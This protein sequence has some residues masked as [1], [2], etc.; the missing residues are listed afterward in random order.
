MVV[1]LEVH[2]LK[3]EHGKSNK[4][5]EQDVGGV[6]WSNQCH[7][8]IVGGETSWNLGQTCQETTW[9]FQS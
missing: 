2:G 3:K 9:V 6:H 4:E 7:K 1:L 8:C 5:K